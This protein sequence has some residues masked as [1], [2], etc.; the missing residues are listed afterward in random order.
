MCPYDTDAQLLAKVN[1]HN[2]RNKKIV[3]SL[4]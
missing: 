4:K 1:G 3:T 2:A